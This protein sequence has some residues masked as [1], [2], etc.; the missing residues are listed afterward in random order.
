MEITKSRAESANRRIYKTALPAIVVLT[1]ALLAAP[2][3][4]VAGAGGSGAG[5][6]GQGPDA[7]VVVDL[8]STGLVIPLDTGAAC[9][10]MACNGGDTCDCILGNGRAYSLEYDGFADFPRYPIDFLS[11][12]YELSVDETAAMDDG[13]AGGT[14]MPATG[15]GVLTLK[16]KSTIDFVM[17]GLNCTIPGVAPDGLFHGTLLFSGGTAHHGKIHGVGT[18]VIGDIGGVPTE[19]G[20]TASTET[21]YEQ[22]W[23]EDATAMVG[24]AGVGNEKGSAKTR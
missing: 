18:M 15:K 10:D 11:I 21:Q 17:S 16:D 14:C 1:V 4:A 22:M 7:P 3:G 5:I 9:T 8:G 13:V 23:V 6:A 2:G 24:Y 12:G 19:T 20:A